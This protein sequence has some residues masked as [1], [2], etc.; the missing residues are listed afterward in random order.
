MNY[1]ANNEQNL[2][3]YVVQHN[4]IN[5]VVFWLLVIYFVFC[6]YWW[7]TLPIMKKIL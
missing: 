1:F 6:I 2:L 5:F 3:Y 4:T 7:I